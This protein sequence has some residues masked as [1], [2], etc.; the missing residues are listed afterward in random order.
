MLHINSGYYFALV[1][2]LIWS[3]FIIVSRMG[4]ISALEAYDIIAIRY[5]TCALIVLPIWWFKLRFNLLDK[6]LIACSLIGGLAYA[7]CTFHGFEYAPASHAA[8]LLPGLMP[9]FIIVFSFLINGERHAFEKWLGI[10]IITLGI[11]TLF[12]PLLS[13]QQG[14]TIGHLYLLGG[15]VCWSLFSILIKRWGITP[16][17]VT[18]SLAVVT[19]VFYM[20]VYLTMLPNNLSM[21]MIDTIAIQAVYQGFLATIVQ[22]LCYVRAVQSI[23]PSSMGAMMAIVPLVSGITAIF[24]FGEVVSVTLIAGLSLVSFGAFLAHQTW[25]TNGKVRLFR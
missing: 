1:A 6:K 21:A 13:A 9:L 24:V 19:C 14:L 5:T 23:G 15:S 2:A 22:V 4:G 10:G 8:V 25:F 18:V 3:G 7:L 17:Q 20:P 12:V 16:W 11:L